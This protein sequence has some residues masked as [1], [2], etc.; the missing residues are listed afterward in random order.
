MSQSLDRQKRAQLAGKVK[1]RAIEEG[2][3]SGSPLIE[4]EF[5]T[6]NFWCDGITVAKGGWVQLGNLARQLGE[7]RSCR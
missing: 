3:R 2:G 5:G 4:V 1:R 7:L 6:A